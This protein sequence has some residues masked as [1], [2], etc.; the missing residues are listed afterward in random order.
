MVP[1]DLSQVEALDLEAGLRCLGFNI[2]SVTLSLAFSTLNPC[3]TPVSHRFQQQQTLTPW[4]KR[5][6][7]F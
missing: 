4:S 5:Q 1:E 6:I 2:L 7:L 3:E